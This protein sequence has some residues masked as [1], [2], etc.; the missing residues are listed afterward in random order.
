MS[1]HDDSSN[2]RED[3]R[4]RALS[5]RRSL[6]LGHGIRPA[7]QDG[8]GGSPPKLDFTP[9]DVG[10]VALDVALAMGH[11]DLLI[12]QGIIPADIMK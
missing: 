11:K 3:D 10:M 9:R 2:R 5:Q 6:G 4:E 8:D 7:W 1:N 12:K